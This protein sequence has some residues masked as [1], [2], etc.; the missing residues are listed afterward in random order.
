MTL[1]N[2]LF[3]QANSLLHLVSDHV[4]ALL[5]DTPPD[6]EKEISHPERPHLVILLHG[7]NGH[8][9]HMEAQRR[10]FAPDCAIHRPKVLHAGNCPLEETIEPIWAVIARH[11]TRHKSSARIA[12]IGLSNGGRVAAQLEYVM[13]RR[14]TAPVFLSTM[15]S[16]LMGTNVI[17]TLGCLTLLLIK[18]TPGSEISYESDTA[19]QLMKQMREP[20]PRYVKRKF[21]LYAAEGDLLVR[22]TEAAIPP[23]GQDEDRILVRHE[24][25]T[26][27]A[28]AV[29]QDQVQRW[30][31]F[32]NET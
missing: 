3:W 5:S 23:L 13:R 26:S 27:I 7:I 10:V 2:K 14:T 28:M 18:K 31:K 16:P 8:P 9:S 17:Q 1:V 24:G 19:V 22:P 15:A 25:H 6:D 21:V 4:T 29:A 11:I 30:R 12:L 32:I 20:L